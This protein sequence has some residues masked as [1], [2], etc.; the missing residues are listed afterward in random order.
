MM[1]TLNEGT[2]VTYNGIEMHNV[3]TRQW[4]EQVVYDESGTDPISIRYVLGFE[5]ILHMQPGEEGRE[6]DFSNTPAWTG[7]EGAQSAANTWGDSRADVERRLSTPRRTLLIKM[8][9]VEV[10]RVTAANQDSKTSK[11]DWDT[12]N[13]PKPQQVRL[14]HIVSN[15]M[16]RVQFSIIVQILGCANPNTGDHTVLNNRWSVAEEIDDDFYTTKTITGT[17]RFSIS[18]PKHGPVGHSFKGVVVPPLEA[19]FRRARLQFL[20]T[21]DGLTG[22]YTVIDRQVQMAAP[23]PATR[24]RYRHTEATQD[25]T[26]FMRECY[27]RLDGPPNADKRLLMARAIQIIENRI[28]AITKQFS[29][30]VGQENAVIPQALS[31]TDDG[32]E[33]NT[34]E[35]YM[36][37]LMPIGSDTNEASHRARL[38][39]VLV[40]KFGSPIETLPRLQ[41]ATNEPGTYDMTQ[42]PV[43]PTYGFDH[44]GPRTPVASFLYQV[45]L[46]TQCLAGAEQH[47]VAS[48]TAASSSGFLE[49]K[50]NNKD[51]DTIVTQA[52]ADAIPIDD[53]A[54]IFATDSA[55]KSKP[56]SY[57]RAESTYFYNSMRTQMPIAR[58]YT[59]NDSQD[60]S[61]VFTLGGRQCRREIRV[62]GERMNE[63]PEIPKPLDSY[64]EGGM[65]GFRLSFFHRCHAPILT[66][67]GKAKLFRITAYYVYAMNRPPLTSEKLSTGVLPFTS[68]EMK[69]TQYDP[70]ASQQSKLGP[71]TQ[72]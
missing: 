10:L 25:G 31:L 16:A 71:G 47:H 22:K 44:T 58:V 13:G 56:Y 32:G 21:P 61:V 23:W 48:D 4:D 1:A 55:L 45:Y 39:S 51:K 59:A 7:A 67:D 42:S 60:T 9:D 33:R 70:E 37:V 3:V 5:G 66:V 12:D 62:D 49:G 19:G 63:W 26:N 36:R 20:V 40:G 6:T 43:M 69:D 18:D 27:V 52:E 41:G 54:N 30:E 72:T 17:V 64:E 24:I 38:G 65:T 2:S 29:E 11:D 34:V 8:A 35:A 15:R 46:Q 53:N 68:M 28:P 14:T 57:Y 50:G